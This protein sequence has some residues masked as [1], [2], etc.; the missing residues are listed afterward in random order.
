MARLH[1]SALG[2]RKLHD[3]SI[4][5]YYS[6]DALYRLTEPRPLRICIV[7]KLKLEKCDL[8]RSSCLDLSSIECTVDI[9]NSQSYITPL[10]FVSS[11]SASMV[12]IATMRTAFVSC[13]RLWPTSAHP[14][15]RATGQR[16]EPAAV[17][18]EEKA[19]VH[20]RPTP[21]TPPSRPRCAQPTW[22]D[23]IAPLRISAR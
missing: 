4:I 16:R 7:R 21:T 14:S 13:R 2:T 5:M 9:L 10:I 1:V 3:N 23:T 22:R 18:E 20:C 8:W 6:P 19:E 17:A 12:R 11:A 15:L